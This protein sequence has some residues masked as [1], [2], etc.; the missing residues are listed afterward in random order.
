M[1]VKFEGRNSNDDSNS[2]VEYPNDETKTTPSFAP[3]CAFV[4]S[5]VLRHSSLIRHSNFGLRL[6]LLRVYS[7]DMDPLA[8]HSGQSMTGASPIV[9]IPIGHSPPASRHACD[10]ANAPRIHHGQRPRGRLS[11]DRF[12]GPR[13]R[14]LTSRQSQF[15]QSAG[16]SRFMDGEAGAGYIL[17]GWNH[18]RSHTCRCARRESAN[19][20]H[21]VERN[22]RSSA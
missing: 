2:N 1:P 6:S 18:C 5:L 14:G 19:R 16:S 9:K 21:R 20:S 3:A 17:Q 10:I 11:S 15:F 22:N 13:W 12:A 8:R 7:F 4:S